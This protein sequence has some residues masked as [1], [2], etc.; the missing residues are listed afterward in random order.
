MQIRNA[1]VFFRFS[2][3]GTITLMP[4]LVL[5]AMIGVLVDESAMAESF[6]G[7]SASCNFSGAAL[8]ALLMSL[9]MHHLNLRTVA[10]L[11]M[12]L[13]ATA[14]L[15]SIP[16]AGWPGLFLAVRFVAGF[17][18][19]AAY[20]AALAAFA[21]YEDTDR[22]YGIF[23]T[24][25]FLVS[26]LGLYLLPVYSE[27]LSTAGMFTVLAALDAAAVMLAR[28]LPGKAVD[29]RAANRRASEMSV[30]LT[31]VAVSALLGFF[32][33]EAA[34]TA[35]FTYVERL[36][37]ALQFGEQR[38]GTGLLIASL[39]GIPGAFAIVLIG[40]RYGR[41][42]P[43]LMGICISITGLILLT[44]TDSY[45]FYI[46]GNCFIGFAWAFCLPFAQG[47]LASLD[48]DGSV[49][50]AGSFVTTVGGAGGPGLAALLVDGGHYDRVFAM[51]IALLVLA[52]IS[53]A[54]ANQK[55][56]LQA[57]PSYD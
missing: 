31:T 53:F 46:L 10:T 36:G 18:T 2:C 11:G 21:R 8:V 56:P 49:L 47:L 51:A 33:F 57:Q 6:A 48:P 13:A 40:G 5:P 37:M 42:A 35:Q 43:L 23:I 32:V 9:R 17:G 41:I 52:L 54:F 24:L 39:V 15:L 20:T 4:L 7:W 29:E 50:A 55:T 38:V 27:V 3:L 25:Q 12:F 30:L 16:S 14:D 45:P 44:T 22:G 28:Y 26:G 1:R 34:N 19:G